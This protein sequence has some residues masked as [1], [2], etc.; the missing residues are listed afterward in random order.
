MP[1]TIS[2]QI[3]LQELVFFCRKAARSNLVVPLP[4]YQ[5]LNHNEREENHNEREEAVVYV[6]TD[7]DK[8][9][10]EI[11]RVG[12]RAYVGIELA[13]ND[14][15]R[16]H[17]LYLEFEG[18]TPVALVVQSKDTPT[19]IKHIPLEPPDFVLGEEPTA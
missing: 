6:D 11:Y 9:Y 5:F 10:R 13:L 18:D 7:S 15:F 19:A 8:P 4:K 12:R 17:R 1:N 16:A 3:I 2:F 14:L